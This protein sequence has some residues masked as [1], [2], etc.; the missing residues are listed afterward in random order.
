M[1]TAE[2]IPNVE[3]MIRKLHGVMGDPY[4]GPFEES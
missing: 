4:S 1:K 2:R 3:R